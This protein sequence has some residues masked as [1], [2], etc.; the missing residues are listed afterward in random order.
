MIEIVVDMPKER[1]ICCGRQMYACGGV[2]GKFPENHWRCDNCKKEVSDVSY[3][4][5]S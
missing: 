4:I 5:E 3:I 2:L 1:P